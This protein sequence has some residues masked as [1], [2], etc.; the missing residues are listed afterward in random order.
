MVTLPFKLTFD[1]LKI[2]SY[3]SHGIIIVG[4]LVNPLTPEAKKRYAT[5]GS[6]KQNEKNNIFF[7]GTLIIKVL[8]KR[9]AMRTLFE[10]ISC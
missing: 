10:L 5:I 7:I 1:Y 6:I 4:N 3:L 2:P 8:K 9:H